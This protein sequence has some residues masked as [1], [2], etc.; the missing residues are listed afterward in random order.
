MKDRYLFAVSMIALL[1]AILA[2]SVWSPRPAAA[3]ELTIHGT[4]LLTQADDFL[5]LLTLTNDGKAFS[6]QSGQFEPPSTF[7]DQQGQW[8]IRPSGKIL[9]RTL[10]FTR[11][12][13]T[14]AFNGF[15]RSLFTMQLD[16]NGGVTGEVLVENF[17][18][19]ADPLDLS[20]SNVPSNT[21]GPTLFTGRRLTVE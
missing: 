4:Y 1:S 9:V 11:N 20:P 19:T 3:D 14:G 2:L 16:L 7:G 21:F 18:P 8:E 5:Q 17:P 10:N 12:A 6:Q 13:S 15:G